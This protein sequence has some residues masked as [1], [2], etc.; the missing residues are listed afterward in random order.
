M[1]L[2]GTGDRIAD[3]E[4]LEPISHAFVS[5]AQ[6]VSAVRFSTRIDPIRRASSPQSYDD[7]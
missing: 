1:L 5:L 4:L 6:S 7:N 2:L 3:Q